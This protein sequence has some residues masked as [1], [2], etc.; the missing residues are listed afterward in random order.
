MTTKSQTI[1]R[2][3]ILSEKVKAERG[4]KLESEV[5]IFIYNFKITVIKM[6]FFEF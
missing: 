5:A 2:T 6:P 4:N 1:A 3:A